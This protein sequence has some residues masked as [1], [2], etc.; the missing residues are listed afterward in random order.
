ML[1]QVH[2]EGGYAYDFNSAK[3]LAVSSTQG[4]GVFD[5]KQA[6]IALTSTSEERRGFLIKAT[7]IKK[8]ERREQQVHMK[9]SFRFKLRRTSIATI[10]IAIST[11]LES[12]ENVF[13]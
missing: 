6:K 3:I 9:V 5:R 2:R 11:K 12:R 1:K 7:V 10:L 8:E 13:F 4:K